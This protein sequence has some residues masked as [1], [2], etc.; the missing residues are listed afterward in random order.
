MTS[1]RHLPISIL[2]LDITGE[3]VHETGLIWDSGDG[4]MRA[5]PI[6]GTIAPLHGTNPPR[7]QLLMSM[8]HLDGAADDLR[9]APCLEA[10][11]RGNGR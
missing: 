8:F 11:G 5:W 10:A 6:P 1:G 2:G 9:P 3:D 4:D 7:G